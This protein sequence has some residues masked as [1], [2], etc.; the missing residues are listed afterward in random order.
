MDVEV[1]RVRK[2]SEKNKQQPLLYIQTVTN[3]NGDVSMQS[4]FQLIMDRKKEKNI[5]QKQEETLEA[6]EGLEK[7]EAP[8]N[9]HFLS[10]E[11]KL[12]FLTE[13]RGK[14]SNKMCKIVTSEREYVGR[15]VGYKNEIVEVEAPNSS[16]RFFLT[17]QEL[18]ELYVIG[19]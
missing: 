3:T 7:K 5:I 18:K 16:E 15:V 2:Q 6:K 10:L 1:Q 19:I 12:Q 8:K 13:Q 4:D 17:F 9:F 11:E 14:A